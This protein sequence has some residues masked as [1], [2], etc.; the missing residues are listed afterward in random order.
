M[1]GLVFA[2]GNRIDNFLRDTRREHVSGGSRRYSGTSFSSPRAENLSHRSTRGFS[3]FERHHD[4]HYDHRERPRARMIR[5]TRSRARYSKGNALHQHGHYLLLRS[6]QNWPIMAALW[7][8]PIGAPP[9]LE[10]SGNPRD[11]SISFR[12]SDATFLRKF[13]KKSNAATK[14]FAATFNLFGGR[15]DEN[16][17]CVELH[18]YS[19]AIKYDCSNFEKF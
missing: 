10:H 19:L 11:W 7:H 18:H 15:S 13:E 1:T 16:G 6:L 2:V 17:I 14:G 4:S 8:A 12:L 9:A 5:Q 3:L